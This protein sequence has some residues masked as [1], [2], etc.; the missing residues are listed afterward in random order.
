MNTAAECRAKAKEKITQATQDKRHRRK[1][2]SAAEA[3]LFLAE[4]L[5]EL[6]H[7]TVAFEVGDDFDTDHHRAVRD[8]AELAAL[9]PLAST[10]SSPRNVLATLPTNTRLKRINRQQTSASRS[11]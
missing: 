2:L 1:L 8:K 9:S 3:W 7:V 4:R 11:P 6:D 10:T 5:D